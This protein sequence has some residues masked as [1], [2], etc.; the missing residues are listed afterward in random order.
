M[1]LDL[2]AL[3][4]FLLNLIL[5]LNKKISFY[6]VCHYWSENVKC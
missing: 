4:I 5:I 6:D 3:P 2:A 1:K